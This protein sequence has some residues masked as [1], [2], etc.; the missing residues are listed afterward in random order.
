MGATLERT[1]GR[2]GYSCR[3]CSGGEAALAELE[4]EV[5]DVVVTDRK[6][7]GMDGLELLRRVGE[8]HPE[9][10]VI[11]MTAYADVPSA[12]E[13]MRAGAFDYVIKPFDNEEIRAVVARALE[14][15]R[16]KRENA[17]L[18]Q[19]IGDRHTPDTMVA[20]SEAGRRLLE[21][22]RRVAPAR[23]SVLIEGE[24]GTGKE[25]VARL[26][27]YWSD[28]V[29]A[30][31]VAVN[32]AALAEG[33]LESELFGHERGAFTGAVRSRPGCFE[34]ADG[35]TLFLDEIG[36]VGLDFQAKLLRVLQEGEVQRVGASATRRVDVR[37]V[38]ASNR[39]LRDAIDEGRFR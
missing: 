1:L 2:S 23:A 14:V 32:C 8:R 19:E 21:L 7:P 33:V 10:P 6:M 38:A 30:P 34:R 20:E 9:V 28:R 11:L 31:F 25:L 17:Y 13:A 36:E 16:L 15:T 18:R 4:S 27:H 22:V 35:G 39:G 26:L 29:A 5:A 3:S 37:V 12:V 24:S